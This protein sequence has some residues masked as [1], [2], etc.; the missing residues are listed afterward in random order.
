MAAQ[1]T[2]PAACSLLA[3]ALEIRRRTL[4]A[5]DPDTARTQAR[6]EALGSGP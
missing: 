6:L 5:S 4:G 2:V 1:T 3:R